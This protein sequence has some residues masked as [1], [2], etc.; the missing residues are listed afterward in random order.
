MPRYAAFADVS[1]PYSATLR[2]IF[3]QSALEKAFVLHWS[4][5][6]Q[7]EWARA[8]LANRP[9]IESTM[10]ARTQRLMNEALPWAAVEGYE[11]RIIDID[12]PDPEARHVLAAAIHGGCDVILTFNLSDFPVSRLAPYGISALDPD[13]FFEQCLSD[14][15]LPILAAASGHSAKINKTAVHFG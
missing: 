11:P 8:L 12:L 7:T 15:P 14:N 6:V 5:D 9:D 1:V 2:D 3:I 4:T 10:V 13:P